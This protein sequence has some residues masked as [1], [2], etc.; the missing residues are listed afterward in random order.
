MPY[1]TMQETLNRIGKCQNFQIIFFFIDRKAEKPTKEKWKMY[2]S[3]FSDY[4]YFFF[5][6]IDRKAKANKKEMEDDLK[7]G[8]II[9]LKA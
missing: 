6:I 7:Y 2:M 1:L 8:L 5:F 3:E 4:R 9:A